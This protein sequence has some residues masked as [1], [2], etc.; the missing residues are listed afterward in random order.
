MA[1]FALFANALA[2]G[3]ANDRESVGKKEIEQ[4]V[5]RKQMVSER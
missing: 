3:Y 4:L 5:D 2:N 1:S